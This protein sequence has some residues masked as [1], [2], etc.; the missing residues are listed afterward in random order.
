[1]SIVE[2]SVAWAEGEMFESASIAAA[3]ALTISAGIAFRVI[4]TTAGAKAMLIPLLVAGGIFLASGTSG[5]FS[6]RARIAEFQEAHSEDPEAFVVEERARVEGFSSLFLFTMILAPS[7]FL[8]AT[9]IF[10]FTLNAHARAA[11]IAMCIV[12]LAGLT[13]D[14]FAKERADIYYAYLSAEAEPSS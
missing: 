10:V 1:M 4:G 5:Y 8:I 3:G 6:N 9:L 7:L 2:H 11:A 13:I 12:G 14:F